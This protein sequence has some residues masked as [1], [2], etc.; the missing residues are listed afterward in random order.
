MKFITILIIIN[1][2]FD[3]DG[4]SMNIINNDGVIDDTEEFYDAQTPAPV[5]ALAPAST[6]TTNPT[7]DPVPA[8]ETICLGSNET[9]KISITPN[10]IVIQMKSG[11]ANIFLCIVGTSLFIL[12]SLCTGGF[13]IRRCLHRQNKIKKEQNRILEIEGNMEVVETLNACE[14]LIQLNNPP[15]INHS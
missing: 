7:P 8:S 6:T 13:T 4:I 5:P 3:Y 11:P 2:A 10:G 9:I 12:S 1:I 14:N 15:I